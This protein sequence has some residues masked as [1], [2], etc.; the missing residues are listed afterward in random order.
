MEKCSKW[1]GLVI[2]KLINECFFLVVV[3]ENMQ[4][5]KMYE[6]VNNFFCLISCGKVKVGWDKLVGE[7]IKLDMDT[8]SI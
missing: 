3:A 6:L 8:A 7:I 4:G 5:A 1:Q 2:F